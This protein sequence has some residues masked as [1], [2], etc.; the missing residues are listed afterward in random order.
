MDS[1][2]EHEKL[3]KVKDQSQAIGEFL[4]WL[5]S[6]KIYLAEYVGKPGWEYLEHKHFDISDL[7]ASFFRID[8]EK[9]EE[10][11]RHMLASFRNKEKTP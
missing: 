9:L 10:E 4:E 6:Q 2:P 1:Y 11:K 8:R 3:Q 5:N 7:L